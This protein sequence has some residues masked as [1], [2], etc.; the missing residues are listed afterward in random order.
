M[1]T[2]YPFHS[3]A[4]GIDFIEIPD[5][6]GF[7]CVFLA[8]PEKKR[9]II[10]TSLPEN[11]PRLI[12][13]LESNQVAPGDIAGI[14]ITHGHLDH[15]GGARA[16]KEWSSAPLMAHAHT[17]A[18]MEN[19]PVNKPL[20]EG[21]RIE[22]GGLALEV[23]HLPGH[24]EGELGLWEATRRYIFVGDLIQGGFDASGNWLGLFTD[25]VKQ[26]Q[27]LKRVMDLKPSWLF[28]GHRI[29]R[30]G[31]LINK[32]LNS[33]LRRLDL[34]ESAVLDILSDRAA[35][36][37]PELTRVVYERVLKR[38]APEELSP[39]TLTTVQAFLSFLAR[40]GRAGR[41]E[42]GLWRLQ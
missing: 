32:D 35:H 27:S 13:T 7:S 23:L 1:D 30:T 12:A 18:Q 24:D 4:P 21:D 37:V 19:V 33:A 20:A 17:A 11:A 25:V 16:L 39:Y 3:I 41:E 40:A 6:G 31:D 26:R 2:A 36:A 5:G 10:D 9:L 15:F 38:K 14:V 34:I 8:G 28:K 42:E 22:A 29:A